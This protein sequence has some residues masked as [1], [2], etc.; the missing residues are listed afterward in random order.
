MR[1]SIAA[2]RLAAAVAGLALLATA[3]CYGGSRNFTPGVAAASQATPVA[4][5]ASSASVEVGVRVG[6]RA[7]DFTLRSLDG[8]SVR[9]SDLRGKPVVI[10]FWASWCPPCKE[11]MPAFQKAYERYR[12]EGVVFLGVDY[13]EDAATV[14]RF[15][16]QNGYGWT[17]LLDSDGQVARSYQV[18]GVPETYFIDRN[19]IVR[20]SQIGPLTPSMLDAKLSKIR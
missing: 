18:T 14:Q 1:I 11:E 3:G 16:Q 17:F 20:D 5:A 2:S 10:N 13:R 19:G 9:L 8:S 15:V 4:D 12:S 6:N 7:P